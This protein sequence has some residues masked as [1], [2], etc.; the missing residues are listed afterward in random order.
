MYICIHTLPIA[1]CFL[2]SFACFVA[3]LGS[4]KDM[5]KPRPPKRIRST[6]SQAEKQSSKQTSSSEDQVGLQIHL[7]SRLP[8]FGPTSV[9]LLVFVLIIGFC[10][11]ALGVPQ[12]RIESLDN[13]STRQIHG[14][15]LVIHFDMKNM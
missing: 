8:G 15:G 4:S 12:Q 7:K 2:L 10:S 13:A 14:E 11:T 6:D 1:P 9:L 3:V 5:S